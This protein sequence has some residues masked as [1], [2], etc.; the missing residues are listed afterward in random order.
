[1]GQDY[2]LVKYLMKKQMVKEFEYLIILQII[3]ENLKMMKDVDLEK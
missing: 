2:M 1:M 3:M